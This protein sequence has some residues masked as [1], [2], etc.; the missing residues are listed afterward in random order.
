MEKNINSIRHIDDTTLQANSNGDLQNVVNTVKTESEKKGLSMNADKTKTMVISKTKG[1]KADI[2]IDGKSLEQVQHFKYLSQIVNEEAKKEQ[3]ITK[4]IDE[5]KSLFIRLRDIFTSKDI[6]LALRLRLVN[7][8]IHP[9]ALY[10]D[11][12]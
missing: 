5:A 4:R 10:G 2:K 6:S 9:K 12:T 11:K 1:N 7:C 8:Y 3:E